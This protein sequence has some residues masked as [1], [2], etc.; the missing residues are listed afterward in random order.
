[1]GFNVI[2]Q[3]AD[4]MENN[5]WLDRR[6]FKNFRRYWQNKHKNEEDKN[7]F[8]FKIVSFWDTETTSAGTKCTNEYRLVNKH[9]LEYINPATINNDSNVR[10]A[11]VLST[12]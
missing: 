7:A 11:T 2:C 5:S 10:K 8:K 4:C 9:S 1:M 12:F 6:N 3:H